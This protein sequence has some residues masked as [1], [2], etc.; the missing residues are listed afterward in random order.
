MIRIRGLQ[1]ELPTWAGDEVHYCQLTSGSDFLATAMNYSVIY[2]GLQNRSTVF[3]QKKPFRKRGV[4]P[5]P[6][7]RL[8]GSE[9]APGLC[10]NGLCGKGSDVTAN[11][12]S[13]FAL[14]FPA[15]RFGGSCP[16]FICSFLPLPQASLR[17]VLFSLCRAQIHCRPAA[18]LLP[19]Q[20]RL[21]TLSFFA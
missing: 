7:E 11:A 19:W 2:A 5:W 14:P 10:V 6:G 18:V 21:S 16:V 9:W 4:A 15:L 12:F 20:R 3:Q 13:G 1:L 17:P 8:W